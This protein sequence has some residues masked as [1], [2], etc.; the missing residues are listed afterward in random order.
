MKVA[1][2]KVVDLSPGGQNI[3]VEKIIQDF[4]PEFTPR[5]EVLYI[6]D[7]GEKF[8]YFEENKFK[9]LGIQIDLHGKMP[10][11]VIHHKSK[12]WLVLVEAVTSHG[13]VDPKRRYELSRIFADSKAGLVFVTAFLDRKTLN[14]YLTQISWETEV[15]VADSPTH[16]IHFNGE[17]FLGPY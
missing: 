2:N 15:W 5:G 9:K 7:T 3:L 4:M 17:R 6:G 12:G 11:V 8:G 14:Q 1:P 10:D 16:L 13:P